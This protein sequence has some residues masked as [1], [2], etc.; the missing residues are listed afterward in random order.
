MK[1]R[2]D[3]RDGQLDQLESRTSDV[4]D[5]EA[6]TGEHL[7]HMDKI[8][9]VIKLKNEDLDASSRQNIRII[10][11]PITTAI[12]NMEDSIQEKFLSYDEEAHCETNYPHLEAVA[13]RYKEGDRSG[14]MLV[15][16]VRN[17][18]AN[19]YVIE[20]INNQQHRGWMNKRLVTDM[21]WVH[22]GF[23]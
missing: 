20:L 12:V 14:K 2:V 10:R 19:A 3:K 21:T 22:T 4:E 5:T 1:E 16:L 18:W 9:E 11:I 6:T 7:L 8:L 17:P 23:R 13:Q 15:I